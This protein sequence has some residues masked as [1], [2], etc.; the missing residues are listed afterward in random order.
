MKCSENFTKNVRAICRMNR[1]PIGKLE[2]AVGF[3]HGYL[4]RISNGHCDLSLDKAMEISE[5]VCCPIEQL[6]RGDIPK[7]MRK[8]AILNSIKDL[9]EE[10]SEARK[11]LEELE[12]ES[13]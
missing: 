12:H 6:V 7:R 3:Q 8:E 13:D 2:E 5:I 10:I 4:S 9:E 11:E 1:M